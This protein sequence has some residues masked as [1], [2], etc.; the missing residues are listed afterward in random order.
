MIFIFLLTITI[1]L[2]IFY[3][4]GIN[5]KDKININD[6]LKNNYYI[7]LDHRTDRNE[8]NIKELRK[9]G[10]INPNRFSAIKTE[11]GAVGCSMSHIEVLKKAK[12]NNWGYVTIF[13][14]DVLFL[15][16]EETLQKL[17]RIVNSDINW[18]V[19][20]LGGNNSL[21]YE[22][23][24]EDCIK[25]NNCQCCSAYI[26]K[27]SYYDTLINHW[28]E[29]LQKLIETNDT[30]KYA[31]DQYWKILQKRDNFLLIIPINVVQKED[32]S[33]IEKTNVNYINLMKN[34]N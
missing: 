34:I 5:K 3:N 9:I 32:Y 8:I 14:D 24:N 4:I 10:I 25:V 1:I 16:P 31:L 30:P 22:K 11:N 20:I 2:Y 15:K 7:N 26:V 13:E 21:P 18:D 28:E 27:K 17:N 23:I 19:I 6:I 29:G 12:E 33:D